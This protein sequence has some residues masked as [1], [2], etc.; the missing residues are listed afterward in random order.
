M[1]GCERI[2]SGEFKDYSDDD[3]FMVGTIEEAIRKAKR[4]MEKEAQ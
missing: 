4:R 1:S 2:L 3:F